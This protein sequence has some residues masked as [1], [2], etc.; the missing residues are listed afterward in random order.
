[1]SSSILISSDSG[2]TGLTGLCATIDAL[3]KKSEIGGSFAID[4]STNPF[5]S[6]NA[7]NLQTSGLIK[8]LFPMVGQLM[9]NV[10]R[11]RLGKSL[12]QI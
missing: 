8:L 2:S 4:V 5:D 11:K 10:P 12:E 3:I 9:R 6:Q 7:D 1:M